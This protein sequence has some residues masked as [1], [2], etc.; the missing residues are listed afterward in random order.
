MLPAAAGNNAS[1]K[2]PEA[3]EGNAQ[4]GCASGAAAPADGGA[5]SFAAT[6]ARA[7]C[8]TAGAFPPP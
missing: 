1:T 2:T 7:R 6:G 4:G 5:A 3:R 8:T